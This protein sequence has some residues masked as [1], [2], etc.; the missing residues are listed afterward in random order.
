MIIVFVYIDVVVDSNSIG[1]IGSIDC[2]N[3]WSMGLLRRYSLVVL[4]YDVLFDSSLIRLVWGL[5]VFGCMIGL[6]L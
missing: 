4:A 3:Y 5:L 2:I 6:G 1:E